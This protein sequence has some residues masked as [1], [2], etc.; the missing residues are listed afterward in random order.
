M[1]KTADEVINE[2]A[3]TMRQWDGE[4]I[5]RIAN[6]VLTRQVEYV[7]D[8]IFEQAEEE[9]TVDRHDLKDLETVYKELYL[10]ELTDDVDCSPSTHQT[11]ESLLK[12]IEGEIGSE[13]V[14]AWSRETEARAKEIGMASGAKYEE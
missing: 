10:A 2:I 11:R 3:E 7:G 5:E 1:K 13:I 9:G 8:S 6:Q 14:S 4:F 12:R